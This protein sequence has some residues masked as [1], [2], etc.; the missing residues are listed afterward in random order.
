LL[1]NR[2]IFSTQQKNI[3]APKQRNIKPAK[4]PLQKTANQKSSLRC[5]G[6]F[7]VVVVVLSVVFTAAGVDVAVVE[8]VVVVVVGGGVV[9]VV[10]VV[11]VGGGSPTDKRV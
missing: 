4:I 8:V 3:M 2:V 6:F 11:V 1:Q 7:V 5:L 9:V 10:V